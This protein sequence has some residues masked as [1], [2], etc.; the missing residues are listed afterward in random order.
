MAALS[1]GRGTAR[2]TPTGYGGAADAKASHS[3]ASFALGYDTSTKKHKVVRIYYRG[4]GEDKRPRFS[5]CEVYVINS[6]R[7]L[8]AR[9]GRRPGETARLGI[10]AR[11]KYLCASAHSPSLGSTPGRRDVHH[12]LLPRQREV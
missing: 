8:A 3:Y 12:V 7:A 1:E 6:K 11:N 2:A 9:G 10:H 4:C 5:G